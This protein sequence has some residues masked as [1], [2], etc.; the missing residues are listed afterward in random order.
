MVEEPKEAAAE[1][2][3]LAKLEEFAHEL[4]V[5]LRPAREKLSENLHYISIISPS[6]FRDP[7][8]QA[9]WKELQNRLRGKTKNI[10]LERNPIER[11]T[12][13]NATLEFVLETIWRIYEECKQ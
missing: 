5:G 12:V 9:L 13:R 11:L 2:Y 4:F 10:W 3:A 7:E 6:D 1:G 8:H